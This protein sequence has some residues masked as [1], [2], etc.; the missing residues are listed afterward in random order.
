MIVGIGVDC[1]NVNRFSHLKKDLAKK[2]FTQKEIEYCLESSNPKERFAAR[3]C[4]KEAVK[5]ALANTGINLMFNEIE[6]IKDG[7]IPS[8]LFVEKDLNKKYRVHLSITHAKTMAVAF[9]ILEE[10][11]KKN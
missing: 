4:A 11:W 1:E 10:K 7:T 8:I 2:L 6:V 5:K 3:F 9:A